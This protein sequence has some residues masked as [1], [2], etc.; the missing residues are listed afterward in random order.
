MKRLKKNMR[1][2][3]RFILAIIISGL[4]FIITFY[5]A[6]FQFG[7]VE[8]LANRTLANIIGGKLPLNV[9]IDTIEGNLFSV[10]IL[11]DISLTYCDNNE[12]YTMAHIPELTIEYSLRDLW[13]GQLIFKRVFIDSAMLVLKQSP[14]KEWLIPKP[15]KHSEQ[16]ASFN[17][18]INELGLNNLT[19]TLFKP[20]DTV[21]FSDIILK[22]RLEGREKTYA[23]DID[24]LSYRSSDKRFNLIGAGGKITLTGRDL[25]F[26]DLFI[27]TDS[28]D[29]RLDGH[30]VLDKNLRCNAALQAANINMTE[31]S[32]FIKATLRG[33]LAVNGEM[34]YAFNTL[35]GTANVA[36]EF[37][38]RS[39]DSVYTRFRFKDK[40]LEFDTLTGI[41]LKG[42]RI[43]AS[44]DLDFKPNPD[45]YTLSG[46]IRDFDLNNVVANTFDTRLSG[47]INIKGRGL[48]SKTLA[49]DVDAN[50]DE[51]WFDIYHGHAVSGNLLVTT[52]SI[53]FNDGFKVVYGENHFIASGK[54][55]YSGDLDIDGYAEFADLSAFDS[56][57][58]I[59]VLGGRGRARFKAAG[60]TSNP[61]LAG[62]FKS[63]SLWLYDIYSSD[64]VIDF[65][66]DRFL[67]D[68]DGIAEMILH[69]GT[70][71]DFPYDTVRLGMMV[72]SQYVDITDSYLSNP[73]TNAAGIGCLDYLSF[74]QQLTIDDITIEVLG[75]PFKNS[76]PVVIDIDSSGYEFVE[77]RLAPPVGY[78]DGRGYIGYD[79]SMNFKVDM[80][81][82]EISPWLRLFA[83]QYDVGGKMS[84]NLYIYGDFVEPFA[85]YSGKIDSLSYQGLNLGNLYTGLEYRDKSVNVDSVY[86]DSHTGYYRAEGTFPIDLSFVETEQRFPDAEQ[87]I[88]IV[89][90]DT[91]FDF[92]TLMLPEVENLQGQLNA[93]FRLTGEPRTPNIDGRAQ[94]RNGTLKPFELELPLEDFNLDLNMK[95]KT[96]TIESARAICRNGGRTEGTISGQGR[97]VVNSIDELV[98][99]IKLKVNNFPARYELGDISAVIDADLYIL[100]ATPPTINGDVIVQSVM[101]R[102][103]FAKKDE[104]WLILSTL[105]DGDSWNFNLDAEIS[106]NLW[107]KNDDIDAELAGS[108]NLIREK[109]KYRYVGTMEILRGKGYLADR[110][111]RIE[112]G[113]MIYYEDI[114]YP[115]PRLDI[116]A[117]T[118]IRGASDEAGP[119]EEPETKMYDLRTHV[120]GTQDVPEISAAEDSPFSTEE[121]LTLIFTNYYTG[122][123]GQSTDATS[124]FGDRLTAAASG[125]LSSQFTQIGSRKLG[126]ET[127]EIDPVYG[128]KLDPLGTRL[129]VGFYTHP[130][131]YVYGRSALSGMTGQEV[132]FEYR[133]K[134]FL[135]MEGRLDEENYII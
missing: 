103:N 75:I 71:Y 39:F 98:Y 11:K 3:H 114:E 73:H 40:R 35:T 91:R 125:Y 64:A 129:T 77:C 12:R 7:L 56:L 117:S 65:N 100:G 99:D 60:K 104:G 32:A 113:G 130:N 45:E 89:A 4:V 116:Y 22:A 10:L 36:G 76:Q 20:D 132:G 42:C 78:I 16:E 115:N 15:Q 124:Q 86:L 66:I 30:L 1:L 110:T 49:L 8:N 33:N 97:I 102:E 120:T 27:I 135:L 108:I 58:F 92:L 2:V 87:L 51:S 31:V 93:S 112:P 127:F 83:D 105:E 21:T 25:L 133:L 5:L 46:H 101:Y 63:D 34:L 37:M 72:D 118:R 68:R 6:L 107:I 55:E 119:F 44:G 54:L 67:Y 14:D 59:Q 74:P 62:H 19:L 50:L 13:R 69:S 57:I 96:I 43:E 106:S 18:E 128:D 84:G 24:G 131:L 111:F 9:Y 17:F 47:N 70:I 48:K 85:V 28:S 95:N 53:I 134:R 23:M 122:N 79:Q 88:D 90:Y 82:I 38:E 94:I 80:D 61:D 123:A 41:V 52:D 121:I 81:R 109:G 126:V 26:H 29:I